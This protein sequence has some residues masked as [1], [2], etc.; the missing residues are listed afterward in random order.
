MAK[1]KKKKASAPFTGDTMRQVSES[2]L[3]QMTLEDFE[4]A[5]AATENLVQT[6]AILFPASVT[7]SFTTVANVQEF[8]R[9]SEQ[10]EVMLLEQTTEK[11]SV[12]TTNIIIPPS[13]TEE[14]FSEFDRA[15]L[16]AVISHLAAGNRTMNP[17]MILRAMTGKA[18]GVELSD[19]MLKE[20]DDS[21]TKC[22]R[23]LVIIPITDPVTGKVTHTLDGNMLNMYRGRH[24]IAGQQVNTYTVA[25]PPLVYMYAKQTGAIT[26]CPIKMLNVGISATKRSLSILN[27][28]Q[29]IV[30]PYI[31][32]SDGTSMICMDSSESCMPPAI[33][34]EYETLYALY[35]SNT[36]DGDEGEQSTEAARKASDKIKKKVRD[37]VGTIL[38]TW[39]E[40]CYIQSWE[41]EVAERRRVHAVNIHLYPIHRSFLPVIETKTNML[42]EKHKQKEQDT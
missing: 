31:W 2:L 10:H 28:L 40:Q 9:P 11:I 34:I 25:T 37:T 8:I 41:N 21:L 3:D 4:Q 29:R 1:P 22:M 36:S 20:V 19:K 12:D 7:K 18:G 13:Q 24:N 14:P 30:S 33:R 39:K 5:Q 27:Y 42:M 32:S 6:P 23:T 26:F 15:V 38:D 17:S 35:D 16:D